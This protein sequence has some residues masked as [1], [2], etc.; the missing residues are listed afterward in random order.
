MVNRGKIV[1]LSM[2]VLAFLLGN[3]AQARAGQ[4]LRYPERTIQI[5][6]PAKAGGDTDTSA[7]IITK[8]LEKELGVPVVIVCMPGASGTIGASH[9]YESEPNGYTVMYLNPEAFIPKAF[10]VS[11]LGSEDFS[12]VCISMFDT[13]LLFLTRKES[14]Y[15]TLEALIAAAKEKP[16]QIELPAMMPGGFSYATALLFEKSLGIDLNLTDIESNG[17][18]IVQLLGGKFEIMGNQYGMVKD[19]VEKGDFI[20]LCVMSDERNPLIP[21]IPTLKELG[22]DLGIFVDKYFFFAMPPGTDPAIV[23]KFSAAVKRTVENPDYIKEATAF[24]TTPH[25]MDSAEA[26]AYIKNAEDG[27]GK[28]AALMD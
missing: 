24:Y 14:P 8:Y 16:G 19:Y 15:Q 18:K 27:Y 13:T 23:A 10:G 9:V 2:L 22:Y 3:P 20:P 6:I 7:R 4:E 28:L 1:A 26:A 17:H 21:D 11:E 5:I 12:M 25:Y